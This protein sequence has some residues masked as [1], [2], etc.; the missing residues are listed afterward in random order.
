M[1]AM[2]SENP[3]ERPR[4]RW[5]LLLALIMFIVASCIT[6]RLVIMIMISN[7]ASISEH[8]P[9][10]LTTATPIAGSTP[11]G[12][13]RSEPATQP[14]RP[15]RSG[16]PSNR[17]GWDLITET[18]AAATATAAAMTAIPP[19]DSPP[20]EPAIITDR[21]P[22][23]TGSRPIASRQNPVPLG[24]EIR[25]DD[26]AVVFTD[27]QR[28][29]SAVQLIAETN[30][31]NPRPEVGYTYLIAT[32][33]LTNIATDPEA[34]SAAFAL[35]VR[36]TGHRNILYSRAGVV[37]PTPLEHDL[38]PGGTQIGQIVFSIPIDETD[39]MFCVQETAVFRQCAA[40]VAIDPDARLVPDQHLA[41]IQPNQAGSQRTAPA[42]M[43]EP[44]IT[45]DWEL[46]VIDVVR[47]AAAIDLVKAANTFN[48]SPDVGKEYVA[49]K[50]RARLINSQHPDEARSINQMFLNITGEQNVVYERPLV[51]APAPIFDAYLFPG[52]I[53]EGWEVFQVAS[54][55]QQL[56]LVFEPP[57]TL[58]A[59]DTRYLSL[60]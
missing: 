3:P 4:R 6:L 37:P 29:E 10:A 52:G 27:V 45:N 2:Q 24:T 15:T 34:R 22:T 28:G 35:D 17:T 1:A 60:E 12:I 21:T 40:F 57:L 47:G 59:G 46:V 43:G 33:Q 48:T 32:L 55:E 23:P 44:V 26:W 41:I 56:M 7:S 14:L 20:V 5:T 9:G 13:A 42:P 18:A 19:Q 49:V 31:F 39:L 16:T 36:V 53:I 25:L 30:P 11:T 38:F 54:G 58:L 50:L 8:E 51:V